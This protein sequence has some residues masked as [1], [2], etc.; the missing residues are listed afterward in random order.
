MGLAGSASV[1]DQTLTLTVVNPHVTDPC[2]AT[3]AVRGGRAGARR[4]VTLSADGHPRAQHLRSSVGCGP[5]LAAALTRRHRR[6]A[7]APLPAGVGDEG[8]CHVGLSPD[9]YPA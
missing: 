5:A 1:N 9:H 4:R 8:H 6:H 7:H 2:D 3:I